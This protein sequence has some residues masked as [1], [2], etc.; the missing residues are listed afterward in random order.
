MSLDTIGKESHVWENPVGT[1]DSRSSSDYKTNGQTPVHYS[2]VSAGQTPVGSSR[3]SNKEY[4]VIRIL[5]S[6]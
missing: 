1:S 5:K 4:S 3:V 6:S 2:R